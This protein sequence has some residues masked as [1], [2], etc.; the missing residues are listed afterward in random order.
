MKM[1]MEGVKEVVM[2][3]GDSK[4]VAEEVGRA[5]GGD[6]VYSELLPAG[7]VEKV[8][9]LL[10]NL[11]K[12]GKQEGYLAF[13]GD[14]INDAPVLSRSDVGIAMGGMGSDAAIEAADIVIMDDD[15]VKIPRV[16]SIGRRT[17]RI[18]TENIVFA[19]GIKILVLLLSA[20]G[21]ANMWAAVFA[22]VGVTVICIV[23][24]MRLL[25]R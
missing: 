6:R 7:K 25:K 2:L 5:L 4:P 19:L 14:G 20:F 16:I 1:K 21:L 3:T 23:N 18:A 11:E 13:V 9:E 24:A 10:K 22:D 17:V 12:N 8:E 15:L